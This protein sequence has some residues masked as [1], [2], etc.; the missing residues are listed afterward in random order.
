MWT[1]LARDGLTQY[2]RS[3]GSARAALARASAYDPELR[4]YLDIKPEVFHESADQI[5][6]RL[7]EQIR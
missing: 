1:E 5:I 7:R 6:G 3:V 2:A 4:K